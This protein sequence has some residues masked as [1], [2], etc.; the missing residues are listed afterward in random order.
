M[1]EVFD[2]PIVAPLSA[3]SQL[4]PWPVSWLRRAW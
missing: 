3:Q 4:A 1:P 2:T